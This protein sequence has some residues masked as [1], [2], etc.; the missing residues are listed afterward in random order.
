MDYEQKRRPAQTHIRPKTIYFQ[1]QL[2]DH[3][4]SNFLVGSGIFKKFSTKNLPLQ[5]IETRL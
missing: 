2:E 4:N 5:L 3:S 1:P